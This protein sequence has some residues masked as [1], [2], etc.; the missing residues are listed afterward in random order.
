MIKKYSLKNGETRF[1]YHAY[2][3]ID[4]VTNKKVYKKKQGFKT[5]KEA[6]LAEARLQYEFLQNGFATEKKSITYNEVYELWLESEYMHNVQEST[7]N[8]TTRDFRNHILPSFN[9]MIIKEIK[10]SYC[11]S[12]LNKWRDKLVNYKRMKNYAA[13][14]FDY[15]LRMDMIDFNPFDKVTMPKRLESIDESEFENYYTKDELSDFLN[16]VKNDLSSLWF[17]Y[18]RLLSFSGAR[19]SEILALRWIDIDFNDNFHQH[20]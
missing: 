6:E 12:E 4:P 17:T 5:K 10:P 16:Y 15:A 14:V 13:R 7:L 3:G 8:K 19:K 9:G 2:L 11:Q 18:F 20:K 1:L